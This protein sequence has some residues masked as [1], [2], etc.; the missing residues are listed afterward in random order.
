VCSSDLDIMQNVL[1]PW[2]TDDTVSMVHMATI[3]KLIDK[4]FFGFNIF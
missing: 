3:L 2:T 1:Q 4:T